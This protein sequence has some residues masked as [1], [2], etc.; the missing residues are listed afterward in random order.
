MVNINMVMVSKKTFE[1]TRNSENSKLM[2]QMTV[3]HGH[4][5]SETV[6]KSSDMI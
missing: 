1:T 6:S 2:F 4:Y 3:D 5:D